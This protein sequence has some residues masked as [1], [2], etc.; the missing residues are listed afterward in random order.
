MVLDKRVE[1][2]FAAVSNLHNIG[3]LLPY[4]GLHYLLFDIVDQPLIMTSANTPGEPMIIAID[5]AL[6]NL[7]EKADFFLLHDRR[8]V[9]RCDDSGPRVLDQ[10]A[11][12]RMSRGYAPVSFAVP[13]NV[14]QEYSRAW[15][16]DERYRHDL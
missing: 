16:R 8:I 9:N 3:V 12:I 5:D 15:R 7:R 10:P 4:S 1:G 6:A 13:V 14:R 2:T 11:F